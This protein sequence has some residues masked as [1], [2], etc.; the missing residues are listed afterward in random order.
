MCHFNTRFSAVCGDVI[1]RVQQPQLQLCHG[2]HHGTSRTPNAQQ[3]IVDS[4]HSLRKED[5]IVRQHPHL[6]QSL[7]APSDT[8]TRA[9]IQ[10]STL[11]PS[12]AQQK[13]KRS[14]S[15]A[16]EHVSSPQQHSNKSQAI[17]EAT[18]PLKCK[19]GKCK[20]GKQQR[21]D[22]KEHSK[23]VSELLVQTAAVKPA[24]QENKRLRS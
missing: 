18:S 16:A 4:K 24:D 19:A 14:L 15:Q 13:K 21:A 8:P 20:A 5:G 6:G 2:D 11:Q 1:C 12:A 23:N 7:S 3:D 17:S 10:D 22:S 9:C